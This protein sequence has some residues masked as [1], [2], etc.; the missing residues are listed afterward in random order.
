MSRD[1]ERQRVGQ[2]VFYGILLLIGY[3]AYKIIQ[4]FLAEIG[5]AVVLAISLAPIQSRLAGRLGPTRAALLLTVLVVVLLVIPLV[6]AGTALLQQGGAIVGDVEHQ[7]EEA[8]GATAWLGRA[9]EWLRERIPHLPSDQEVI[10]KVTESVGGFA[11]FAAGQAG[12]LLKG[13]AFFLVSLGMVLGILF[14]LLRDAP[15]YAEGMKRLLPFGPEQNERL[16]TMTRDLVTASVTTVLT[17]AG[18]Q[19]IIGGVTFALLGIRGAVVWGMVMAVLALLPVGGA[20]LVWA[21][22]AIWLILG[23]SMA[24]GVA[25]LLVGILVMGSVD[26]VVRPWLLSGTARMNTLVLILSLLGGLSAFG[27]LGI[28]L[29]PLVASLLMALAESYLQGEPKPQAAVA[30]A[31]P[32]DGEAAAAATLEASPLQPSPPEPTAGGPAAAVASEAKPDEDSKRSE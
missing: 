13:A 17:I 5:W 15:L 16:F 23:G 30:S 14:F 6:F 28:V 31:A 10:A 12:G 26:N 9:W 18:L 32:A 2:M 7:L 25:L 11:R 21:P 22:T 8:G 20:A 1:L 3:L 19:G 27:F 29:G 4:P 24:R